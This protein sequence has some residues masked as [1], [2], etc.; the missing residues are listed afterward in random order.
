MLKHLRDMVAMLKLGREIMESKLDERLIHTVEIPDYKET[1][2]L[3]ADIEEN[4][5]QFTGILADNLHADRDMAIGILDGT[6]ELLKKRKAIDGKANGAETKQNAPAQYSEEDLA[7]VT[8]K[9]EESVQRAVSL[10]DSLAKLKLQQLNG[11]LASA[12]YDKELAKYSDMW[13]RDIAKID[14]KSAYLREVFKRINLASS[15][16]ERKQAML[17][18]SDI[19]GYKLSEQ[20]FA[21]FMNG[22]K[23]IEL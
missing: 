22:N 7:M 17:L 2:K 18:L 16:Y 20:D 3:P 1:A 19:S 15:E 6:T 11:K 5:S 23:Q 4:L 13:K 12:A 9:A 10:F 14:N 8:D 21:D